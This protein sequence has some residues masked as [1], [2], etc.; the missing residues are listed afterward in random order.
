MSK[1]VTLPIILWIE[2][3]L[4][5]FSGLEAFINELP[6]KLIR[7]HD[8]TEAIKLIHDRKIDLLLFDIILEKTLGRKLGINVAKIAIENMVVNLIAY[9]VLEFNEI[10]DDLDELR[11][12]MTN[13]VNIE[14]FGKYDSKI[15]DIIQV[16]KNMLNIS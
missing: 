1:D 13:N 12:I 16:I 2:D 10:S 7:V 4:Y 6:V 3:N 5:L 15:N 14:H 8:Y 11:D 9:T